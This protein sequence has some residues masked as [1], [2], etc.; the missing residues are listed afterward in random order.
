MQDLENYNWVILDPLENI[1]EI[2]AN[3]AVITFF[4]LNS[5]L[6]TS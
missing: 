5:F 6:N 3:L 2:H 1:Y 4:N